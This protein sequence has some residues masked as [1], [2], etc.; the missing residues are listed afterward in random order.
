MTKTFKIQAYSVAMPDVAL[1]FEL[2]ATLTEQEILGLL[3]N[4]VLSQAQEK[5]FLNPS[6]L[7]SHDTYTQLELDFDT[8][9]EEAPASYTP[10]SP[11]EPSPN[12]S[13][14]DTLTGRQYT[15]YSSSQEPEPPQSYHEQLPGTDYTPYRSFRN[16]IETSD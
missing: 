15:P 10:Y 2:E 14:P 7:S 4:K 5:G 6:I 12:R 1:T 16:S 9:A 11:A 8:D 13:E 3:R